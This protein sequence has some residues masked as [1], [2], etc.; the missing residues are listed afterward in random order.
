MANDAASFLKSFNKTFGAETARLSSE[1]RQI[2][3]DS[4]EFPAVS[5]GDASHFWGLPMGMISQF[6]G[7]EG[8][9]KT[10]FAML[11]VKQ[12]QKKFPDSNVVWFDA[13]Y[14]F[15]EKW[16]ER[17][18]IDL[19]RLILIQENN[20]DKIFTMM[21]GRTNDNGKYVDEGIMQHIAAG[22]LD[23]KLV[24]LDSIATMIY[25]LEENRGFGEHEMAAASR[26]LHKAMRRTL[27]LVAA[28][29]TAFL[30]INQARE[31]IGEKFPTLTYPGG[32]PYR[33]A[34][35]LAVLFRPSTA[36]DGTLADLAEHKSGHR[37]NATVEKTR[38]GPDKWKC[39]FWLDFTKGVVNRG[40]EL[41]ALAAAYDIVKRP[42]NVSW[43]YGEMKVKGKDN[44][45]AAL[46]ADEPLMA[47]LMGEIRAAKELGS[48]RPADF[49]LEDDGVI[50]DFE[51]GGDDTGSVIS[52]GGM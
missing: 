6:H 39:E 14:S 12:A 25:P 2:K 9:G 43:E 46:E 16:A 51:E 18:G 4:I 1:K 33:H 8:S 36:K 23:C 38:G 21:C 20:A 5:L 11:M 27:P 31:K 50:S 32:R 45:A 49:G 34:I 52:G 24:V 3:I 17:L 41:A 28:T 48:E 40:A 10:F 26:F 19:T 13:E 7:P 42:N 30:C 22:E 44:F 47:K 29:N 35:S 37:I 15:Q